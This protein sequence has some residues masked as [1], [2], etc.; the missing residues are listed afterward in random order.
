M[1]SLPSLLHLSLSRLAP[2]L[3]CLQ[4]GGNYGEFIT[5]WG[6][7]LPACGGLSWHASFVLYS[8]KSDEALAVVIYD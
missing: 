7:L 8:R 5:I 2:A 3:A 4:P 6:A 1:H